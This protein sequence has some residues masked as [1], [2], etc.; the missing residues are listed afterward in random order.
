MSAVIRTLATWSPGQRPQSLDKWLGDQSQ[1]QK[2]SAPTVFKTH[3]HSVTGHFANRF[4][5]LITRNIT[6][7]IEV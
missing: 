6:R 3:V 7:K 1:A 4:W 2:I 5:I